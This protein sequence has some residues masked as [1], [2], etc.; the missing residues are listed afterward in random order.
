MAAPPAGDSAHQFSAARCFG[1]NSGVQ[2]AENIAWKLVAKLRWNAG[3]RLLETYEAERLP[4]AE[5]NGEQCMHNTREM[6]KTLLTQD[7]ILAIIETDEGVEA[8]GHRR[9]NQR[10]TYLVASHG[11]QFD[12]NTKAVRWCRTGPRSSSPALR[13]TARLHASARPRTPG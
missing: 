10:A 12:S 9:R 7:K 13:T 5:F 2:D 8:E 11:Q 6:E 1:L 3:D 4:V